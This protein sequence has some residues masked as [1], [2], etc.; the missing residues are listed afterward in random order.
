MC[1]PVLIIAR[2]SDMGH[3]PAWSN[4]ITQSWLKQNRLALNVL[5]VLQAQ[6]DDL[7]GVRPL[8]FAPDTFLGAD[9]IHGYVCRRSC[10]T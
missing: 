3:C 4:S 10:S 1:K 5:V 6:N 7:E 9:Y 2:I 8:I